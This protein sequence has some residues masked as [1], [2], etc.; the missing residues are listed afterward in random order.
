MFADPEIAGY[1]KAF[2]A[3]SDTKLL[4]E[5]NETIGRLE[6]ENS[7]YNSRISKL[8]AGENKISN[9]FSGNKNK[10]EIESLTQQ[11]AANEKE[12]AKK[13]QLTAELDTLFFV[14]GNKL[15]VCLKDIKNNLLKISSDFS[16]FANR[17]AG[18]C[19]ISS[20]EQLADYRW[21]AKAFDLE[22]AI[23]AWRQLQ[24]SSTNYAVK[25]LL[26]NA[27]AGRTV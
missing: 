8:K 21:V 13:E 26:A 2:L 23:L 4:D 22:S 6:A 15:P 3:I 19:K 1:T 18:I 14:T 10:M 12:L 7:N 27:F 24:L 20:A 5:A 16:G 9:L 11:I 17:L 25:H